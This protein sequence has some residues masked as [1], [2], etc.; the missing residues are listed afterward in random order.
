MVASHWSL[1]H[2]CSIRQS[3]LAFVCLLNE[4]I[5]D[6]S[7]KYAW[8]ELF[9]TDVSVLEMRRQHVPSLGCSDMET[10]WTITHSPRTWNSH[11]IMVSRAELAVEGDGDDQYFV[12]HKVL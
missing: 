1:D 2:N 3:D 8:M 7:C 6:A 11:A 4:V 5:R 9:L 12:L 10:V